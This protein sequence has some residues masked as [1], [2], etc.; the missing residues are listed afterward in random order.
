MGPS[1]GQFC[2][3]RGACALCCRAVLRDDPSRRIL[4]SCSCSAACFCLDL[5]GSSARLLQDEFQGAAC[6]GDGRSPFLCKCQRCSVVVVELSESLVGFA[7]C[8]WTWLLMRQL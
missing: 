1:R 5:P 3:G 2:R 6:S 4:S 7:L 8:V